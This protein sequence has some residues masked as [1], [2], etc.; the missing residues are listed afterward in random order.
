M[1]DQALDVVATLAW[2]RLMSW[3]FAPRIFAASMEG[4]SR[5]D[6]ET[7]LKLVGIVGTI[8]WWLGNNVEALEELEKE[9]AELDID[10]EEDEDAAITMAVQAANGPAGALA[11]WW[12]GD[13]AVNEA[14]AKLDQ[15]LGEDVHAAAA[16]GARCGP[17]TRWD[18]QSGLCVLASGG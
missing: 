5:K 18:A 11:R 4:W 7:I 16:A 13:E 10:A 15:M 9:M 6:F 3:L 12:L 17:G 14:A 2:D 8:I 1:S